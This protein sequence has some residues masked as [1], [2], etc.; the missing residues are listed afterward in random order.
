VGRA[1]LE[2]DPGIVS[3]PRPSAVRLS[4]TSRR[5]PTVPR[6]V[7]RCWSGGWAVTAGLESSS[8]GS[9][10]AF[11]DLHFVIEDEIVADDKVVVRWTAEGT[12][13]GDFDGIVPTGRVVTWTGIDIV[14]L[15]D[16]RIVELW[17]NN[18]GLGLEEQLRS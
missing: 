5:R 18:D 3:D 9:R 12:H 7:P 16:H 11:P 1:G 8:R 6:R 14:H 15:Q 10:A 17:G 4:S 13:L 2:P